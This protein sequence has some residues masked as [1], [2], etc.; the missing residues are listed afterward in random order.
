[1]CG[2][3]RER[4]I[5]QPDREGNRGLLLCALGDRRGHRAVSARLDGGQR[6]E[7]ERR[8]C[9]QP[10]GLAES[11]CNGSTFPAPGRTRSLAVRCMNSAEVTGLTVL[12]I[13]ST[14]SMA[15]YALVRQIDPGAEV[16]QRLFPRH[17]DPA[18]PAV[19]LP[20]LL[21]LRASRTDRQRVR[22]V[23]GV[24]GDLQPLFDLPAAHLFSG[25]PEG[26]R[27]SRDHGRRQSLAGVLSDLPAHHFAR[28]R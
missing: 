28:P 17:D 7:N 26:Y 27:G 6:P 10:A 13:C 4:T 20:A 15:A 18:D 2:F 9:R 22:P 24:H 3:S 21:R 16:D 8:N 11:A 23:A 25:D 12:M 14:G 19:P 5:D 1:M